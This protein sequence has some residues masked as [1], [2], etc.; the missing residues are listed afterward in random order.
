M[1]ENTILVEFIKN[2]WFH[3]RT[4]YDVARNIGTL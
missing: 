3:D 4:E 2:S 1:I